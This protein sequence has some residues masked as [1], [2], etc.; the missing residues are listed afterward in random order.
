MNEW[1]NEC[2]LIYRTYHITSHGGLQYA[3]QSKQSSELAH[4]IFLSLI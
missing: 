1:M 2:V 4:N 3:L